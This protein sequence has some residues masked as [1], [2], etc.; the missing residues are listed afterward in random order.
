V[1]VGDRVTITLP[2]THTTAGVVSHVGTVATDSAASGNPL[3][4]SSNTSSVTVLVT[5]SDPAATGS[6]DQSPVTVSITT[7]TVHDV[8]VVPVDALLALAGGGYA[9]EV[10]PVDGAHHL[11]AVAL[12]LFDDADGAVQVS[13]QGLAAGQTVVVPGG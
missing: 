7:A 4:D 10:V 2:D 1:K 13:G 8:L 9:V 3:S 6:L 12:G 5:P 11:V